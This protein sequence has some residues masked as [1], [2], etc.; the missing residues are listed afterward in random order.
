MTRFHVRSTVT[1]GSQ[2]VGVLLMAYGTPGNLADVEPYY[3]DIRRGRKPPPNLLEELIGR[4]RL[5]GGRTPLLEISRSQASALEAVLGEGF[6]V[7]LGMKHWHPYIREAMAEMK[8]EGIEEAVGI[9]L[10][11]HFSGASIGEY[12]E[13]VRSA[14]LDLDYDLDIKVVESWHLSHHYLAA[15]QERIRDAL[16]LFERQERVNVIFTAHSLPE[17][18]VTGGD[19]Y[20]EQL[21]ETSSALAGRLA[22]T[23]DRWTFSFQSAG[24]TSDRWLGPDI[25]DTIDR[26]ANEGVQDVLVAPIGFIADHLEILYDIDYEARSAAEARGVHLERIRSLNDHP[27]LIAALADVAWRSLPIRG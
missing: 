17:R 7:F 8:A 20:Q 11:P 6:R 26:L 13:R 25:L 23:D 15:V 9:V 10:A 22:L 19:P 18:V 2:P 4:Y 14:K 5:V 1:D 21:L 16:P 27:E 24:S 3:T 12:A